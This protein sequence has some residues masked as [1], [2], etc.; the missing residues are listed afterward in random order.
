MDYD[1]HLV[2]IKETTHV[3]M[4]TCNLHVH[5]R[6]TCHMS[7]GAWPHFEVGM[8][9]GADFDGLGVRWGIGHHK[10]TWAECEQVRGK[11][12]SCAYPE[13]MNAISV[14]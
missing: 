7:R 3:R 6:V 5:E 9:V 1:T 11:I 13:H 8:Q 14:R 10:E 4:R 12:L 2:T